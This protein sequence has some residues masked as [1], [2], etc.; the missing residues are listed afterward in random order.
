MHIKATREITVC[1][2]VYQCASLCIIVVGISVC[3]CI[4]V[5]FINTVQLVYQEVV[6]CVSCVSHNVTLKAEHISVS[7]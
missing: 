3:Q 7:D 1:T 4:R 2:I 6:S 5:I